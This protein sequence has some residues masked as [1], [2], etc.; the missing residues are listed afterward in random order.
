LTESKRARGWSV[1]D[2][3]DDEVGGRAGNS[4][5]EGESTARLVE[6][7]RVRLTTEVALVGLDKDGSSEIC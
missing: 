7:T 2:E 3:V 4:G 5:E 1:G 6:P